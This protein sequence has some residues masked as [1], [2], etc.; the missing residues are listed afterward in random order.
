MAGRELGGL[1]LVRGDLGGDGV[2]RA[3]GLVVVFRGDLELLVEF[4]DLTGDL[5]SLCAL[6]VDWCGER[7]QRRAENDGRYKKRANGPQE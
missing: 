3:P 7:R 5:R 2:V 4:L 6:V 1:R